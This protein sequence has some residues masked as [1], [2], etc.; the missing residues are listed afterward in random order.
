MPNSTS[1]GSLTEE[2]KEE[3]VRSKALPAIAEYS[4]ELVSG[5]SKE[6]KDLQD[7]KSYLAQS[8]PDKYDP[9]KDGTYNRNIDTSGS[10]SASSMLSPNEYRSLLTLDEELVDCYALLGLFILIPILIY[11]FYIK[12]NKKN[13]K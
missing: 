1:F 11:A 12:I 10:S 9:Y 2:Q 7:N 8:I 6:L 4:K 13:Y 3:L 5:A